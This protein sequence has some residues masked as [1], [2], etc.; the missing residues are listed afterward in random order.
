MCLSHTYVSHTYHLT[1]IC[2]PHVSSWD[3]CPINVCHVTHTCPI[4]V[5]HVTHTCPINVCHVT[6]KRVPHMCGAHVQ[7]D[8]FICVTLLRDACDMYV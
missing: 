1:H 5:C 8:S 4:N 7:H 6:H 3:T 2:V